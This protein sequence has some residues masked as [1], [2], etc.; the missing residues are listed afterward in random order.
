MLK[1]LLAPSDGNVWNSQKSTKANANNL[2]WKNQIEVGTQ[3]NQE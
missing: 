1:Y 3:E 2:L